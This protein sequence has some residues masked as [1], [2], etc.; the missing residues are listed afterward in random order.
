[1]TAITT[2]GLTLQ[3]Q[4]ARATQVRLFVTTC[5]TAL[6]ASPAFAQLAEA[7]NTVNWVLAI[8]SPALLLGLLTILLVGCGLAVFMGKL[9][10]SLFMKILVGSVFVFGA[11]TLAPKIVG[12]F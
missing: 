8:F 7:E 4:K 9:S 6:V 1:M 3:Q 12:L 5:M 10:G 2:T 11:R